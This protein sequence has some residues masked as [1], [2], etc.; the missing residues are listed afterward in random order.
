MLGKCGEDPHKG[1]AANIRRLR[2]EDPLLHEFPFLSIIIMQVHEDIS[3]I[4]LARYFQ[5][6]DQIP[7]LGTGY[8]SIPEV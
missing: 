7:K 1:N 3:G 8:G 5:H 6:P 4:C 2:L